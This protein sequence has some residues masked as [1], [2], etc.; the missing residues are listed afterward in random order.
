MLKHIK[1]SITVLASVILLS[2][3]GAGQLEVKKMDKPLSNTVEYNFPSVDPISGEKVI[4]DISKVNISK[5]IIKLSKYIKFKRT[6]RGAVSKYKGLKVRQKNN[7]Y[8][9]SYS[10]GEKNTGSWYLNE[11][12]FKIGYSKVG[13]NKI[14][15]TLEDQYQYQPYSNAIG[16]DIPPLG[17]LE[18][19]ED[20]AKNIL[21]KLNDI[22]I[23]RTKVFKFSG[24][25]NSKYNETSVY[26][27]FKRLAG[28]FNWRNYRNINREHLSETRKANTFNLK[29][30]NKYFPLHVEVFPYRD[31]SKIK[32]SA[33]IFYTLTSNGDV[34]VDKKTIE[35]IRTDIKNIVED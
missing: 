5:D 16:M 6:R 33:D 25:L 8:T 27:N 1:V 31:G 17:K 20:D 22:T 32:Y 9:L 35:K 13:K 26:S 12:I 15:Y 30:G 4:F 14:Q 21:K 23:V 24:E 2:G 28:T 18:D 7:A 3:C 34:S 19:L 29:I 10:N 11:A